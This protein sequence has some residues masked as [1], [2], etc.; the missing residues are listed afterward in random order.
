MPS[1]ATLAVLPRSVAFRPCRE[2]YRQSP[3]RE[4]ATCLSVCGVDPHVGV[5]IRLSPSPL[6]SESRP[7]IQYSSLPKLFVLSSLLRLIRSCTPACS[8][9]ARKK[10]SQDVLGRSSRNMREIHSADCRH[11]FQQSL[12]VADD[13]ESK[14]QNK[15][16]NTHAREATAL[17]G[18]LTSH[19][20]GQSR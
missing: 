10:V 13:R 18:L 1:S 5:T 16:D 20:L 3:K 9:E 6:H 14:K 7:S 15:P 12:S 17:R 2:R 11:L 4:R 8:H 19:E